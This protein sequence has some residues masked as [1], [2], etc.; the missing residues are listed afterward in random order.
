MFNQLFPLVGACIRV[1]VFR[2]P[3][4]WGRLGFWPSESGHDY[5]TVMTLSPAEH[6]QERMW[7]AHVHTHMFGHAS[8]KYAWAHTLLPTCRTKD[9]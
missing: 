4:L 2:H 6:A 9:V 7:R 1:Y 5:D 3:G 8:D